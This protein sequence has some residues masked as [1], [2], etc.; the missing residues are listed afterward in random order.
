MEDGPSIRDFV[1]KNQRANIPLKEA[2]NGATLALKKF[3]DLHIQ[4]VCR[5]IINQSPKKR[6]IQGTGGTTILC[7]YMTLCMFFVVFVG[8]VFMF[9]FR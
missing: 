8:T 6:E 7:V 5:Y 9:V 1:E 3:R 2:F 4:I